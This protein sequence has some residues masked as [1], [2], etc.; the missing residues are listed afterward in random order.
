MNKKPFKNLIQGQSSQR[1][2]KIEVNFVLSSLIVGHE[3]LN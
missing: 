1:T 3:Y 2:Y